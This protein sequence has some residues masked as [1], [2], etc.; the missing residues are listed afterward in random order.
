[1]ARPIKAGLDVVTVDL[2]FISKKE[3]MCIEA[4]HGI[5]GLG[6]IIKLL[7]HLLRESYYAKAEICQ[8][9]ASDKAFCSAVVEYAVELGIFD[10]DL[11]SRYQILTSAYIQEMFFSGCS[12]RKKVFAYEEYLLLEA[13]RFKNIVVVSKN[14]VNEH[15]NIVNADNNQVIACN[16]RVYDGKNIVNVDINS[17]VV[18]NNTVNVNNIVDNVNNILTRQT[19]KLSKQFE[20]FFEK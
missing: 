6:L 16:N 18:N 9:I 17:D 13:S 12:R 20:E 8:E 5:A 2:D 11:Y 10:K 15:K 7:I 1:M 14:T 4:R 3:F 19:K